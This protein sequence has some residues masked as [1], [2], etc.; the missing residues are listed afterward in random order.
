[1]RTTQ[2]TARTGQ[3]GISDMIISIVVPLYKCSRF[4]DEL[5]HR[6]DAAFKEKASGIE[7]EVL[8]V[9]DGSPEDDW[10]K[11]RALAA[12]H[13]HIKGINLSR[14]FGQHH[15]ITAGIDHA[16]GDWVVVMD[17]DLQD[18]PEE[19][20]SLLNHARENN[21]D[22]VFAR[23]TIRH[24]SVLKRL[25]S[26]L[27]YRVFNYFAE[28]H[29][30]P[31]VANFSIARQKVIETVR[32]MREQNRGFPFFLQW[33]GFR[34]GFHT[35]QHAPRPQGKSAYSLSRLVDLAMDIIIANSNKP[36][37]L[38]IKFGFVI[39]ALA[40]LFAAYSVLRYFMHGIPVTGWTSLF[41]SI[42]FLSGPLFAQLG[43][44]GMYIGKVFNETKQRPL[45]VVDK[46][47]NM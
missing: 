38:S 36:L 5:T 7:Y 44:L 26:R 17:G 14:N 6:I 11:V 42:W 39:A 9:N 19:I 37:R 12:A 29:L 16:F 31:E 4:V 2:S 20:P 15:A 28:A 8:L 40:L 3:L 43:V 46:T 13:S 21:L 18:R 10:E 24:D 1:M 30:S 27:F 45:Y 41:V 25:S 35:V 23:R 32:G 47:V 34:R 22:V 33:A